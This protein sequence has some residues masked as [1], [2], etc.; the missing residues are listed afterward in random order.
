MVRL[1]RLR[2]IFPASCNNQ[3]GQ[4]ETNM[5][6]SLIKKKMKR[7]LIACECSQTEC[8]AFRQVGCDAWSCDIQPSYGSIPEYHIIGDAREAYSNNKWDM[9]IAHPPCTYLSAA[10]GNSMYPKPGCI[11][12]DRF[13]KMKAARDL[14]MWFWDNVTVP[15]CIENPRPLKIANLPPRT[16]VVC[17]SDFGHPYTKRTYLWLRGLP[18]LLPT[19]YH[20]GHIGSWLN[21]CSSNKNRR[22]KAFEGL[23]KAMAIQWGTLPYIG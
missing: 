18:P 12:A 14:F 1:Q 15:L 13:E 7:V 11:D 16:Q 9:V 8:L 23:A 19:H 17:P 3:P 4:H 22:S 5:L 6:P 21:H 10:G 2:C 20:D